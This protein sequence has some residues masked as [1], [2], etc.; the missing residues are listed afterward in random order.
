MGP[1]HDL[2]EDVLLPWYNNMVLLFRDG[3]PFSV[4][5]HQHTAFVKVKRFKVL[6]VGMKFLRFS[7]EFL[8]GRWVALNPFPNLM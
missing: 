5:H 4:A 8:F 1:I 7:S 3:L 6:S 2:L